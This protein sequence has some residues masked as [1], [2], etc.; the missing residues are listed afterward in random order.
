MRSHEADTLFTCIYHILMVTISDHRQQP[1]SGVGVVM[2]HVGWVVRRTHKAARQQ[3]GSITGG[4]PTR[5]DHLRR[6]A[7]RDG[8][9]EEMNKCAY[10]RDG[11]AMVI[12]P[13]QS[14]WAAA[15]ARR[16]DGDRPGWC[17]FA[18]GPMA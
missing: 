4:Q 12:Q 1:T 14:C 2:A 17:W 13:R 8:E 7:E 6:E 5:D 15:N 11:P 16:P 3:H 10:L 18:L 9:T